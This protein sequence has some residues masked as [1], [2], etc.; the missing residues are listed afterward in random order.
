MQ[1]TTDAA[2]LPSN[3]EL[4][5]L[6]REIANLLTLE[7]GN[8][9][10][11]RMYAEAAD[12]LT[13]FPQPVAMLPTVETIQ[14][15]VGVDEAVAERVVEYRDHGSIGYLDHLRRLFPPEVKRLMGVPGID[16]PLATYLV[17]TLRITSLRDL[18]AALRQGVLAKDPVIGPERDAELRQNLALVEHASNRVPLGQAMPVIHTLTETLRRLPGVQ[19]LEL[20]GSARRWEE[21]IGDIDFCVATDHPQAVIDAFVALPLVDRVLYRSAETVSVRLGS[22][23]QADLH[24]VTGEAFGCMQQYL[25]GSR[26]H[27]IRLRELAMAQGY[28][29]EERHLRRTDDGS[30]IPTPD[31]AAVY[32]HLGLVVPPP[33][34]R[35]GG[36]E[37]SW[38][39]PDQVPPLLGPQSLQGDLHVHSAWDDGGG[40]L[41]DIGS[42]A[43]SLGYRYMA[44]TSHAVPGHADGGLGISRLESQLRAIERYN[45][46][47]T[48]ITFLKAI[49][50]DIGPDGHL[51]WPADM[52]AKVDLVVGN[53]PLR[54]ELSDDEHSDRLLGAILGNQVDILAHPTGR[55]LQH[56]DPAKLDWERLLPAAKERRIVWEINANWRR[57]DLS[58]PLA[59]QAADAEALLVISSDAHHPSL[60][61]MIMFG[62][63]IA[64]RAML[65]PDLVINTWSL[66]RLQ[67]WLDERRRIR[68][69]GTGTG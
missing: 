36:A 51:Q 45:A 41:D 67:A 63:A 25:T 7:G 5:L 8:P 12:K 47:Q 11:R 55:L 4:A 9:E 10:R 66:D 64:R 56:R 27:N 28:R 34:L 1:A 39:R 52:R 32:R 3:T 20:V 53:I 31:E 44:I 58:E 59:R 2:N 6:L 18:E 57:L 33:E 68:L 13:A 48:G 26:R 30:I 15:T 37:M 62:M 49:E 24:L 65:P 16:A 23:L 29:L 54:D 69:K 61:P 50:A 42:A 14:S 35:T 40:T 17:R 60:L 22:G 21:T 46:R 38:Q 43:L 19:Q